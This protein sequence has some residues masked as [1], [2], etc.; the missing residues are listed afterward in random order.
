MTATGTHNNVFDA[1]LDKD[2]VPAADNAGKNLVTNDVSDTHDL[3]VNK[4][5][6]LFGETTATV[7]LTIQESADGDHFY[8][9]DNV[10][11]AVGAVTFRLDFEH[12][13]KYLRVKVT[14]I[15]G[16][17]NIDATLVTK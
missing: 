6:T 2:A 3:S 16:T 14:N 12:R 8:D 1:T 11:E 15:A 17:A 4:D 5:A 9:T 10:I 13:A 7:T